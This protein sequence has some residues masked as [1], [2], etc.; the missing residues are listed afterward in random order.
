MYQRWASAIGIW[1]INSQ[2]KFTKSE[3][4]EHVQYLFNPHSGHMSIKWSI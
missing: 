2:K 3:G 1:G 4:E